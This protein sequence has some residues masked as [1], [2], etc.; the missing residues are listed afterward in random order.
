[1]GRAN[2]LKQDEVLGVVVDLKIMQNKLDLVARQKQDVA[3]FALRQ[4]EGLRTSLEICQRRLHNAHYKQILSQIEQ[5]S[6]KSRSELET[7]IVS[8]PASLSMKLSQTTVPQSNVAFQLVQELNE[9]AQAVNVD[10]IIE[11]LKSHEM[12]VVVYIALCQSLATELEAQS[13][14][15]SDIWL[16]RPY[17]LLL[18]RY[19]SILA[20][21]IL[22]HAI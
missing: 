2:Y 13:A 22:S 5:V 3:N 4:Q 1:M 10:T 7:L 8:E 20:E 17:S 6:G 19:K 11:I 9:F 15:V 21:K 18:G 12:L 14:D 16:E